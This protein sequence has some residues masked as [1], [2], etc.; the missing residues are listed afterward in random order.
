MTSMKLFWH[1]IPVLPVNDV[2]YEKLNPIPNTIKKVTQMWLN[3]LLKYSKISKFKLL[4]STSDRA[5][6]GSLK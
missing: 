3:I 5:D 4:L 6:Y 1:L 2:F